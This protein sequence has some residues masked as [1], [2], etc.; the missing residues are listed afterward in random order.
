MPTVPVPPVL[1]A[2]LLVAATGWLVLAAVLLLDRQRYTWRSKHLSLLRER[3]TRANGSELDRLAAEVEAMDFDDLVLEG[4]P[5]PVETALGRA[6]LSDGRHRAVLESARGADRKDVW[7]RIRAAQV[8]TSARDE[9]AHQTLNEM[10]RSGDRVLAGSALRLFVRLDDRRSAEPLIR[11]LIDDAYSRSRIAAAFTALSVARAD[12][13][14]PLFSSEE[15]SCRYWAAR[16]ACC[17][18]MRQWAPNVRELTTDA[19]PFV[20]RAAVEAVGAI[21]A[22]DDAGA[23][24]DLFSDPI[25]IVRAHAARAAGAFSA[26]RNAMALRQLLNDSTWLVRAAAAEVLG[27]PPLAGDGDTTTV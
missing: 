12:T 3:L 11:A 6:L 13:L 5:L 25:P 23:V 10:L 20:R 19:D 8:L 4:V 9:D 27:T 24:L 26:A 16:L 2:V 7:T 15:S 22:P 1:D 18:L 17:N 14:Q 21:G